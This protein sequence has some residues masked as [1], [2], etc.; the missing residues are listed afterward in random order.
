MIKTY[1]LNEC[2]D[3]MAREKNDYGFYKGLQNGELIEAASDFKY[4]N[5][6]DKI[7]CII[8]PGIAGSEKDI[9]RKVLEERGVDWKARQVD[10][11]NAVKRA[12]KIY[13]NNVKNELIAPLKALCKNFYNLFKKNGFL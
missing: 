1:N 12:D 11:Y 7:K 8:I 13:W 10:R 9:A 5:T 4:S 2:L 3:S 6:L